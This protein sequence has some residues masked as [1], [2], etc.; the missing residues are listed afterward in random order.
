MQLPVHLIT[1]HQCDLPL[2]VYPLNEEYRPVGY[3]LF[4]PTM[5]AYQDWINRFT[6]LGFY[7]YKNDYLTKILAQCCIVCGIFIKDEDRFEEKGGRKKKK[8]MRKYGNI[9][10]KNDKCKYII[11]FARLSIEIFYKIIED[12]FKIVS[13]YLLK[14]ILSIKELSN[15]FDNYIE[16]KLNEH[17]IISEKMF[18]NAYPDKNVIDMPDIAISYIK[19]KA[20]IFKEQLTLL[21]SSSTYKL[22]IEIFILLKDFIYN[23]EYK[24]ENSSY[25]KLREL[26]YQI[27]IK[28]KL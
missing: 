19:E 4:K 9:L 22:R 14:D 2:Y 6:S 26:L 28:E 5:K 17:K 25:M 21:E 15:A 13:D 20:L 3:T 8:E 11:Q 12:I 18:M 16:S 23:L 10:C 1:K 24:E 7:I 27:C